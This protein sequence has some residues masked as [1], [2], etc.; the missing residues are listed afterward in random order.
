[1][2]YND[3]AN[4]NNP[5]FN[6]NI[7][8]PL[9]VRGKEI[10]RGYI[11]QND[12]KVHVIKVIDMDKG[13]YIDFREWVKYGKDAHFM[14]SKHGIMIKADRFKDLISSVLNNSLKYC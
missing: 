11:P 3:Y 5:S 7:S 14:P 8:I 12:T 13:R 2:L 10:A 1:M 6:C 9:D 4:L